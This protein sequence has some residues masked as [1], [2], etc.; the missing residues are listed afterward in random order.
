MSNLKEECEEFATF[1]C[2]IVGGACSF[3]D[4][5]IVVR[6]L[7]AV[8]TILF[9]LPLHISKTL[10]IA[11]NGKILKIQFQK[12]LNC[13][14]NYHNHLGNNQKILFIQIHILSC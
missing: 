13:Y 6:L 10:V 1:V 8:M 9:A 2:L 3:F 5:V 11:K 14:R 4:L 12:P 7:M